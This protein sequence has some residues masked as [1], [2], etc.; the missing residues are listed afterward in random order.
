[1]LRALDSIVKEETCKLNSMNIEEALKI[2]CKSIEVQHESST[3]II[4]SQVE[5]LD[6]F[7]DLIEKNYIFTNE[8][9]ELIREIN[10][11]IK[12]LITY[13]SIIENK[14]EFVERIYKEI[15]Y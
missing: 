11:I 10:S 13:E 6:F 4:K 15:L 9:V 2:T 5:R 7:I 3:K 8:P 1:M 14:L 12:S